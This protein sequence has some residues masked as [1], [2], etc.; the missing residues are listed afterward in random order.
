MSSLTAFIDVK[1]ITYFN[2]KLVLHIPNILVETNIEHG[3]LQW[4][5]YYPRYPIISNTKDNK[6]FFFL[7]IIGA[8]YKLCKVLGVA[9]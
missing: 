9:G 1:S 5:Q 3:I 2:K 6:S 4:F 7:P 8:V